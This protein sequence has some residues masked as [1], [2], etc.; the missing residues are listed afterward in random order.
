MESCLTLEGKIAF[1]TGSTR[2]IGWSTAREFARHGATVILNGHA[3]PDALQNRVAEIRQE[4]GVPCSG[5]CSDVSDPAA[6]KSAYQ[7]IFREYK[8]LDVLVNNAGILHTGLLGMIPDEAIGRV[9]E[10]NSIGP[11]RHLQEASRLMARNRSGSIINVTSIMGRVG[12]EGQTV[13]SA[14]KAA[15]I[16]LTFS[17]AKE[18]AAKNIRVNA[19]A[20][21]FIMT[22]MM[23]DL[24]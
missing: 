1:I 4:F 12:N 15:L 3:D 18:L 8:R 21:G 16:G 10:T 17:A 7:Q 24:S 11:T 2:G 19:V 23:K 13:Y 20:P 9:F 22:D 5:I 6:V 14:S